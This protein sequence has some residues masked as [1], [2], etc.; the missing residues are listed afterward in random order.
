MECMGILAKV[1]N[2]SVKLPA[3]INLPDGTPVIVQPVT[4]R[5][6]AAATKGF[7]LRYAKYAGIVKDAPAD[8]AE[9]H[10]VYLYRAPKPTP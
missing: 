1:E 2:G 9:N 8:L 5:S 7:G 10:D 4:E 6:P 3:G